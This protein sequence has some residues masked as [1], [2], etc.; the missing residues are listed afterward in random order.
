MMQS[1][2]ELI[3]NSC[4]MVV[5]EVILPTNSLAWVGDVAKLLCKALGSLPIPED[6]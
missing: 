3:T 4:K 1:D 6:R 2:A 5:L